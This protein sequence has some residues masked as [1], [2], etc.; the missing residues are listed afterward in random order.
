MDVWA[1]GII[2]CTMLSG[3]IPFLSSTDMTKTAQNIC[4]QSLKFR[5][6]CWDDVPEAA[7]NLLIKM[8]E[9]D[10]D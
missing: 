1:L 2:L 5:S 3:H 8:L 7:C 6:R 4:T 10:P 9:K